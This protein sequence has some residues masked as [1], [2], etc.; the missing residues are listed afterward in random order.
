[1]IRIA[2]LR[3]WRPRL[4]RSERGRLPRKGAHERAELAASRQETADQLPR[5]G[6]TDRRSALIDVLLGHGKVRNNGGNQALALAQA[7]TIRNRIV[8]RSRR[9]P[10][11]PLR[12]TSAPR[13]WIESAGSRRSPSP[14]R[15]LGQA[16]RGERGRRRALEK[17][18]AAVVRRVP[19]GRGPSALPSPPDAFV[20]P[21]GGGGRNRECATIYPYIYNGS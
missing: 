17:R 16:L 21:P 9:G 14:S 13:I 15:A 20:R 2:I 19:A 10:A 3:L 12:C 6:P 8:S 4:R 18:G 5:C 11:S 7:E 1:M